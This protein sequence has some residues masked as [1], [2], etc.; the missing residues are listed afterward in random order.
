MIKRVL[1]T[2]IVCLAAAAWPWAPAMAGVDPYSIVIKDPGGVLRGTGGLNF[3]NGQEVAGPDQELD[4]ASPSIT[5][6]AGLN[7]AFLP[8]TFNT[9]DP[10]D[11]IRVAVV[12][13]SLCN[14]GDR[15]GLKHNIPS[16]VEGLEAGPNVEGLLHRIIG[17]KTIGPT[18]FQFR[19]TFKLT[20]AASNCPVDPN[21]VPPPTPKVHYDFTRTYDVEQYF[22]TA[23]A[24]LP[25]AAPCWK[26]VSASN[27]YHIWNPKSA[28]PIPE[29]GSLALLLAGAAACGLALRTRRAR[30]V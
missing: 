2:A 23:Q 30:K 19:L 7:P 25:N 4:P 1:T 14:L 12:T 8:I 13:N 26:V 5:M 16:V 20:K 28:S 27:L 21:I 10:S 6:T 18:T 17:T 15:G 11:P 3:D 24:C 9:P 29:P 22:T